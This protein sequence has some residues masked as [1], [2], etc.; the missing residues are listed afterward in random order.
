[1]YSG[2]K[3]KMSKRCTQDDRNTIGNKATNNSSKDS[4]F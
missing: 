2:Y 3:K 1:M 4:R